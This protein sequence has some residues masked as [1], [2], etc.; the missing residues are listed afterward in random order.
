MKL[1]TVAVALVASLLVASCDEDRGGDPNELELIRMVLA[2]NAD[3]AEASYTDS[4]TTAQTLSDAID[5]LAADPSETTL[6][7]AREAWLVAREPYGQTEVYRFR[8]S[9][10]DD[11]NYDSADGED[12]P[13]GEINA[14][15]LGEGLIDYVVT[16]T[17][18]GDDQ[19]NVTEHSTGVAAPIPM[20]NIINSTDI[21]I[22]E[23]LLS[24]TATGE[25]EHDVI[26]GYHAI[27]FLL[28]GQ[29]LNE[30]GSADTLGSRDN[31]PGQ[32]PATDFAND[33]TCTSGHMVLGEGTLCERRG[34]F[35]QVAVAKLIADLTSVRDQW[36]E[37][38]SYR[39]AFLNVPDLET[40]KDRLLEILTGMGTLSEGELGGERM[41]IALSANSQEDEH[42]CFS[43]NTHRDIV[44]NALGVRN[45]YYGDYAGYDSSLDGSPNATGN[46]VSGYG[47]DDYL[48]AVGLDDVATGVEAALATTEV[49]YNAIDASARAGTPVDNMIQDAAAPAAQPM[50]DTIVA[51]NAQAQEIVEI[52]FALMLGTADQVV[53]PDASE[54]DTTDPTSEC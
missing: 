48:R 50:R 39:T 23:A 31:T 11:T 34:R 36:V 43:D 13:E 45:S 24:N 12:G 4:I 21:V 10:I 47:F 51:L 20:N 5:A 52:A 25:D 16:G 29:D 44:L 7:A 28:W 17:D 38:G 33:A 8:A 14:W 42:S 40:G 53:I 35:L 1:K 22:D 27:E 46:A 19:I 32:R 41:Q 6:A 3:I 15:P 26:A 37:G 49:G 9:P 54:C 2:T 18:F 30:G